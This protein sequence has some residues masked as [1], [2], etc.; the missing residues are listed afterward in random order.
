M[1]GVWRIMRGITPYSNGRDG[2]SGE[3]GLK[4]MGLACWQEKKIGI[5]VGSVARV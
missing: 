2:C 1:L 5:P 3:R 4:K